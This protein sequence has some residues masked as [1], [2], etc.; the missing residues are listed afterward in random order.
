MYF[1][2]P[3]IEN[4]ND[5][6]PIFPCMISLSIYVKFAQIIPNIALQFSAVVFAIWPTGIYR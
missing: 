6:Q 1:L 2:F 3:K 5:I 4:G